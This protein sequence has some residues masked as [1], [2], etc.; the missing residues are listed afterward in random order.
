[1]LDSRILGDQ[2]LHER[3]KPCFASLSDVVNKLEETEVKREFLLWVVLQI[4][5][6]TLLWP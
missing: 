4:W 6:F 5:T 1:M 3:R 2:E